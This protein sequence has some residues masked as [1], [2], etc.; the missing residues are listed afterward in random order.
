MGQYH[1]ICN[2]DRKEFLHPHVFGDGVKLMEFGPSGSGAMC[3]LAILLAGS[4]RGGA[5]GGGDFD[6]TSDMAKVIAGRWSGDRIAIIG[7]YHKPSDVR[8]C[9]HAHWEGVWSNDGSWVDI[10]EHVVAAMMD[11]R[12][13]AKD[14]KEALGRFGRRDRHRSTYDPAT[15]TFVPVQREE[16]DRP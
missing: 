16:S 12:Y 15:D 9:D 7:D 11:D 8:R 1:R 3:G 14:L 6:P 5:R 4:V 13:L 2:I 10:S